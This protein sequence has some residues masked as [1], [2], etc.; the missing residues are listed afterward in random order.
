MSTHGAQSIF[1]GKG[2]SQAEIAA[3]RDGVLKQGGLRDY[4]A[5]LTSIAAAAESAGLTLHIYGH[6]D[7]GRPLVLVR[8]PAFD[9][10]HPSLLI[11]AGVHGYEPSGVLAALRFLEASA[12]RCAGQLNLAIFP[13]VSPWAYVHDQRWNAQALD[14]NRMFVPDSE[15]VECA[16]FMRALRGLDQTFDAAIDLHETR[17]ADLALNALRDQRFGIE[18]TGVY[19]FDTVPDGA[20]VIVSQTQDAAFDRE[21][22]R[23]GRAVL[24]AIGSRSPIATD[25]FILG[26]I[27][28]QNGVVAMA[29]AA[30]TMRALLNQCSRRVAVTELYPD[31]PAMTPEL[32][33]EAQMKA[34]AAALAFIAPRFGR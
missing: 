26:G 20:Y 5:L 16:A 11:T 10:A 29:P 23:Y 17:D 22:I 30:G 31:H 1:T 34:I 24:D 3:W 13:C 6:D 18:S 14:P 25:P 4:E 7:G 27:P 33:V 9:T 15:A 12:K 2:W 32:T 19:A 28:N 21:Q 8:T